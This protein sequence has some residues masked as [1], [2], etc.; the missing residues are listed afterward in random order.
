M[1]ALESIYLIS[2]LLATT[3]AV[4]EYKLLQIHKK[5]ISRYEKTRKKLYE[6]SDIISKINDENT[7]YSVVLEAIVELIPNATNGSV[8]I[9]NDEDDRF[10]FKVVKEFHRELVNFTIKKEEAYLFNINGFRETAIINNP[11]EFDILNVHKETVK[12]LQRIKALD[13]SCTLSAPIYIDNKFIGLINIDSNIPG[14]TFTRNDLLLMDQIKCELELAIKN[15]LAQNRLKYLADFDE[16]TGLI[17]RRSLKKEFD[18]EI[19]RTKT[20]NLPF[21]L[22]MIDIDDFKVFNDTYGHY[23]GDIVLKH[24]SKILNNSVSE[25]DLVA[26]FAGDEFIILFK[27]HDFHMTENKMNLIRE[28]VLSA[29]LDGIILRFSYGICEVKY[30]DN[31]NFDKALALADIKMYDNKKLKNLTKN[32]MISR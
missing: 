16:L 13:I 10:Y 5:L 32:L 15:A 29:E 7:I 26:R 20:S 28:A 3:V 18:K 31:T 21:C 19:E 12:E 4:Y 23:F 30:E 1:R 11:K 14:H 8:L 9:Y 6:T 2:F 25:P 27:E 24:F 17:N 22:V